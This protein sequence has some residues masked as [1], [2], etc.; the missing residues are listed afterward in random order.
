MTY[1]VSCNQK[2]TFCNQEETPGNRVATDFSDVPHYTGL[3]HW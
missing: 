2:E 3:K 1:G